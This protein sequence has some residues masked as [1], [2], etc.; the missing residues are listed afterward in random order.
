VIFRSTKFP[1][2]LRFQL[3]EQQKVKA[4]RV[5]GTDMYGKVRA[6][7]SADWYSVVGGGQCLSVV[8]VNCL[9]LQELAR[10]NCEDGGSNP[11]R[12]YTIVCRSAWNE[13]RTDFNI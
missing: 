9:Q 13:I 5:S 6:C 7:G 3:N 8:G 4:V 10:L 11:L 2:V 12:K 1:L